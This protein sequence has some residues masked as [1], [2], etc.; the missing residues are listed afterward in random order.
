MKHF[1]LSS[2]LAITLFLPA[3]QAADAT[4]PKFKDYAVA[5]VYQGPTA[6]LQLDSEDAKM[7]I[8]GGK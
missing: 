7:F 3:P 4:A 5:D 1:L 6:K 2:F 8:V